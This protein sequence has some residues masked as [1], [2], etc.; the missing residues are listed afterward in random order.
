MAAISPAMISGQPKENG[1]SF[2]MSLPTA[3]PISPMSASVRIGAP[4]DELA[5]GEIGEAQDRIGER[6][7][8]GAE[9][10]HG[11]HQQAVGEELQV[12][13][14][15]PADA[16]EIEFGDG[17][18][19]SSRS[20]AR[21]LVAVAP[22]DQH[23]GAIGDGQA[24]RGRSARPAGWSRRIAR[25]SLSFANTSSTSFGDSPAEASSSIS[26]F[27]STISARAT[28][29]ICRWPPESRPASSD[30]CRARSGKNSY[31]ASRRARRCALRQHRRGELQ[32]FPPRVMLAK[33]FSVCGT[34]ARPLAHQLVGL[35]A[36]DV[37]LAQMHAAGELRH[38][39]GDRLDQRRFA[40]AVRAEDGDDLA[41][42][43]LDVG[44][45]HDRHVGLVAGDQVLDARAPARSC[46]GSAEIGLDDPRIARRPLPARPPHS[47][48]PPAMTKTRPQ[49]RA[50]RS[51]LC[52]MIS[53]VTPRRLI[54]AMR[55][56]DGLQ[57]QRGLT[58]AA[59]S[60]SRMIRGIGHQDAGQ[61]QQLALSARE[62]PRRLFGE[63]VERDEARAAPSP[64]RCYVSPRR[65]RGGAP[66][67][68]RQQPLAGLLRGGD[69]QVLQQRHLAERAAGSGRCGRGRGR[70][71]DA[72]GSTRS[73]CR[74]SRI[75][76]PL[77]RE[78]A[79]DRLNSVVLPA[80]FGPISPTISPRATVS[81]TPSTAI[82]PP[83]GCDTD[84]SSSISPS[85]ARRHQLAPGLSKP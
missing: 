2:D 30:F 33:T 58:P 72:A 61:L 21:A 66:G 53:N 81:D 65:R 52:S 8:D 59:G 47:S 17:R 9:P 28:A 34:K 7:A 35:A 50:T 75:A 11:A 49:S 83:N 3:K 37:A 23:I 85:T 46:G 69:Q 12:H 22:F 1:A 63:P 79:G 68:V 39:P 42:A 80:P 14:A 29:S 48:R 43:D 26:S 41:A 36:G 73:A 60:S 44:A 54:S 25:I 82:M 76:P 27:G 78:A 51:M 71:G 16:A 45:A 10:D 20:A 13:G 70:C 64:S 40:G 56:D 67:T 55:V 57:E 19:R 62:D 4:G 84:R 32:D 24:R 74:S 38:Q 5:M 77:G 18:C 31:I 15:L 6:D